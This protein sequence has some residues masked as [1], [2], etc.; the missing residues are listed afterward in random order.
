M[1]DLT[2]QRQCPQ[3]ILVVLL[4]TSTVLAHPPENGIYPTTRAEWAACCGGEYAGRQ[5]DYGED[6]YW[7][8][9]E[10][11]STVNPNRR[12]V[13]TPLGHFTVPAQRVHPITQ[14]GAR[15]H[16]CTRWG[17]APREDGTNVICVFYAQGSS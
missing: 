15:E 12:F 8:Y 14:P 10:V 9:V 5:R 3:L 1:L 13:R 2:P 7:T 16:V 6:C 4:L 11:Q 17:E